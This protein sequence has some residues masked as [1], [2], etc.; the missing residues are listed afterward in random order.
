LNRSSGPFY[1][2]IFLTQGI[3]VFHNGRRKIRK[4]SILKNAARSSLLFDEKLPSF[5]RSIPELT[6]GR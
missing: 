3:I 4:P 1:G 5:I 6:M 2:L